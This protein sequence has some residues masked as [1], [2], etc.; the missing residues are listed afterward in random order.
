MSQWLPTAGELQASSPGVL[1]SRDGKA[2]WLWNRSQGAWPG[3]MAAASKRITLPSVKFSGSTLGSYVIMRCLGHRRHW[4]GSGSC[5]AGGWCQ[6]CTPR[7]R[8]WSCWC[9]S[10]S[11]ASCLGNSGPGCRCITLR[12]VRRLWLW[13]RTSRDTSVDQ[14]RWAA[15]S[16][17]ASGTVLYCLG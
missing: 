7:S 17:L 15:E 5:A 2:A 12:V 14:E 9:W 3:A 1:F 6:R 8:S 4:A 13:W 16:R 11:W 10:N